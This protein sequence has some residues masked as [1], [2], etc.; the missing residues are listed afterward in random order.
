MFLS[1][2]FTGAAGRWAIVEKEAYAIVETLVRADY[3]L[4]PA[5]GFNLYTDH[6]NLKFIFSPTAVVAS[7]PKYT[8][9]KL[10]RWALLLMGYS[11]VIHDIPGEH[12]R[13]QAAASA[14][15]A[16][17][18]RQVCLAHFCVHRRSPGGRPR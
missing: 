11:Y 7:V 12:L 4:H 17:A 3:L 2:T 10:E 5:A 14:D 13:H 16:V 8:A 18:G 9:Q 6:R 1:G 15:L